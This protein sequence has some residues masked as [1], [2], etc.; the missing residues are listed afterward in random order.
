[1]LSPRVF[2]PARNPALA[3]I[4]PFGAF[5][6]FIAAATPLNDLAA[7]LP[8]DP[9]WWYAVR[10]VVVA[11]LLVWLWRGYVELGSVRGVRAGDWLLSVVVGVLVFVLWVHL[12]FEPLRFADPGGFDARTEGTI[13]WGF[14]L[15]RLAGA[16]LMVPVMEELFWRSFVMR[17]I[18]KAD[19]LR[20][21][22]KEVG[23][24]ALGI[25]S[26]I[27]AL[28]HHLWFAGLLAGFAYGWLYIRTGNLWVAVL[29][30][31]VTNGALGIWI[32][33]TG[34]WQFW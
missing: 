30:H 2:S 11:G 24:K 6:L 22:P 34:S 19:F 15:T 17:W 23:A 25:S 12:D 8:M 7:Q 4:V 29:S 3:R 10:M 18:E 33:Y 16:A 13:D 5:I 32:L 9:R 1:M 26:A 28:E 20:V 27:F 31:G 21:D 14:A